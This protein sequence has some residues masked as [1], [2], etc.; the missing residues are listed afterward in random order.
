M[1]S[2]E[3]DTPN[4]LVATPAYGGQVHV[5]YVHGL[6]DLFRHGVRFRLLTIGNE[7][8]IT[9]ARNTLISTFH[10][11]RSYTHLLFLDG[12]VQLTGQGIQ[13]LLSRN[14]PVIGAAVA[15]KRVSPNG[16]KVFN[17]Q[18]ILTQNGELATVAHL[19]T[20]VL[21]LNRDAVDALIE[22]AIADSRTYQY[23]F[24]GQS[25]ESVV[26]DY[27]VFQVGVADGKYLSEDFW[28]CNSLRRLG[29][30]IFV[31]LSV[32]TVHHGIQR[33]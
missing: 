8:L 26:Q 12:D 16:D 6:M 13:S 17:Y 9:R 21:M 1:S 20:A 10:R 29:F 30:E 7:S 24:E 23:T 32:P 19:G 5:D 33:F 25:G 11:N 27:D 31:D 3:T 18:E 14:K 28:V 22:D 2:I 4:L 15:L